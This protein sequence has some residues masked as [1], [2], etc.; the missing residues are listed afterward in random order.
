MRVWKEG[1]AGR[2]VATLSSRR[3]PGMAS[4]GAESQKREPMKN[5]R[6]WLD[7]LLVPVLA[8]VTAVVLGGLIIKAAGGN[9]IA[10]YLG[11]VEGAFGSAKALSETAVWA[12]PYIFAG[13]AV[14]VGFQ[15]WTI[16]YRR[17]GPAGIRRSHRGVDRLRTARVAAHGRTGLH[18]H[19][20][21]GGGGRACRARC[22]PPSQV[23]SRHIPGDTKSSTPS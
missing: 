16:Q 21:G 6:R 5:L 22:G 7:A 9:P 23:R 15:G 8:I 1:P 4:P 13:L 17:R 10:G 3:R 11:L 14:A 20:A 12:T 2:C 18:S 19:S